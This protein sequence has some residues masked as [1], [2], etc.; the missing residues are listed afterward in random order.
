M[1]GLGTDPD[2]RGYLCCQGLIIVGKCHE[3]QYSNVSHG[4]Q[5]NICEKVCQCQK[6]FFFQGLVL[7]E[8]DE[9]VEEEVVGDLEA[10]E[11]DSEEEEVR[12]G[13]FTMLL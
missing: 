4:F 6:C 11:E 13:L 3:F 5:L 12:L 9:V 2:W 1:V 10:E 8:E 7:E